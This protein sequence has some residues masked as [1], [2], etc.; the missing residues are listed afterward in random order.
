[1]HRTTSSAALLSAALALASPARA[2]NVVESSTFQTR[3]TA[4]YAQ[5][6]LGTP[7]GW[8]GV[9]IEQTLASFLAVSAGAGMGF[10][11]PQIAAM[12]RLRFGH[13]NQAATF[14]LGASY[15]SYSWDDNCTLDCNPTVRRGTVAWGNVEAG[16]EQ[17]SQSGLSIRLF[18]GYGHVIAGSLTCTTGTFC[19][20]EN[21]DDGRSLVYL[22][23]AAGWAF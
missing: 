3:P 2:E 14:G 21:R 6:G 5:L 22:G 15:G 9:E 13:Q 20:I 10:A 19:D 23:G 17:R 1:M 8:G 18:A 11:G 7:L 12:P 4:I 16:F